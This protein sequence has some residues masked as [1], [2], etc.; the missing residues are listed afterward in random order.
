MKEEGKKV[1]V[2]CAVR[3]ARVLPTIITPYVYWVGSC[4][5]VGSRAFGSA[6]GGGIIARLIEIFSL[7]CTFNTRAGISF[8]KMIVVTGYDASAK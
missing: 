2:T 6:L 5:H 3:R 4:V 1:G 7:R 8:G